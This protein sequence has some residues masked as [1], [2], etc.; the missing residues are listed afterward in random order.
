MSPG[1]ETVCDWLADY[2]ALATAVLLTTA[3][4]LRSLKQPAKRLAVARS[5]VVGLGAL[6]VLV[7]LPQ[8][9]RAGRLTAPAPRQTAAPSVAVATGLN[10]R[11]VMQTPPEGRATAVVV[12][13]EAGRGGRGEIRGE[14]GR[15]AP[16]VAVEAAAWDWQT[17]GSR[18]FLAG[19]ALML[20]WL[21]LGSWQTAAVRRGARPAPEWARE[22]FERTAGDAGGLPELLVSDRVGQ[23]VAVGLRRPAVIL[24]DRLADEGPGPRLEAVLAHEWAHVRNGDLRLIALTRLLLPVLFAH[25]AYWWLRRRVR[26][27]QEVL[28]DADAATVGGR[29]GYAEALLSWARAA[30]ERPRPAV[31]GSLALWE[32]P[33]QLRRRITVLL[34]RDFRVETTCPRSW[35]LG[36][37][38]ATALAVLGLSV[39]TF[40]PA[41]VGADPK[42]EEAKAS[43]DNAPQS[44][45]AA[46]VV[47]PDGQGVAGA[48]VYRSNVEFRSLDRDPEVAALLTR[49]GPDGAFRLPAVDAKVAPEKRGMVVALA[50]GFGPALEEPP[51][52]GLA[53]KYRLVKDDVPIRGRV[54]DVQ[55]RP[56]AGAKVQLVGI[57]WHPS[58][59]LD[60]WLDALKAEQVAYP[61]QY[62]LLRQWAADDL[63]S[64]FPAVEAGA[65]GRFTLQGVGRERVA[66][67]LV[68]GP[69]VETRFE[70]VATREMPAVKY[71][72]FDRQN[73]GHNITYH[74]ASFDLVAGPALEIVGTVRDKDTGKPIPGAVVQTAAAFGNPLRVLKTTADAEGRYRL[75]GI[76]PK[77]QFGDGQDVLASVKGGPPYLPS[78]Q[79]VGD[80]RGAGPVTK[81]FALKR[82]VWARGRITDKTT[83][84]PVRASIDYFIL[85]DNPHLKDFSRYGTVR[86]S[87]PHQADEDGRYEIAVMPGPGVIGARFGN[88]TYRL[89]VG[90]DAIKARGGGRDIIPSRPHMIIATNYNTLAL[91]DPKP[92]DE[93]VTADVALDRGRTLKGKLVGPDGAPV[94]GARMLGAED[95][96]ESWSDKPLPSDEFEVHSLGSEE[97]RGVIFYHEGKKLAGAYVIKPDE[98]GPVTVR[99]EPAGGLSGR[100]VDSG[101]LPRSGVQMT[102]DRPIGDAVGRLE[103]GSIPA[104]IKTDRD[105]RFHVPGLVPGLK[106]SLAAWKGSVIAGKP[107]KDV[108]VKPG[109]ERDLG[110][111]QVTD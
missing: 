7:A 45:P 6:A 62:R 111:V 46:R 28:A 43:D 106:Y 94:A 79:G 99:L 69:G 103:R 109:E 40:R 55:G 64:L 52:G 48:R 75:S 83:G 53:E 77:T 37:R 11:A 2:Y 9:P 68:S 27:D 95:H 66:L 97:P 25:P 31:A 49:T 20:A 13:P 51:A 42:K 82:G 70:F 73:Q 36:A 71:P 3:A 8:W 5:A 102:G 17:F 39:F 78:I 107:V 16:R 87:M 21:V 26:D 12:S 85:E 33:S 38:A 54:L 104:P 74:G 32:R 29:V 34:D 59:S 72:D 14:P 84:K 96:F 91:I 100:L 1:P 22:V 86:V 23:P 92:G 56:V 65:D 50:D 57:L 98:Q 47:G 80:I 63:P 110:D 4:A 35:R 108:V 90:A 18:A 93:S 30:A 88:D 61:V 76:P 19:G 44:G 105:G 60:A 58:G 67:L 89:G 81:D 24:P 15:A 10:D 41:A 101:G